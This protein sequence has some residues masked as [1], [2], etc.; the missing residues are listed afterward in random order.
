MRDAGRH[1]LHGPQ[2]SLAMINIVDSYFERLVE[3][4]DVLKATQEIRHTE[5]SD[6]KRRGEPVNKAT[7]CQHAISLYS[8][9][10]TWHAEL[11]GLGL[12]PEEIPSE[13]PN[14]PFPT[15]LWYRSPGLGAMFMG[16]WA[17]LLVI[18][19]ALAYCQDSTCQIDRKEQLV[20][21]I[22]Q[23]V[24]CVGEDE[25]GLYRIAF[26]IHIAFEFADYEMQTW[27]RTMLPRIEVNTLDIL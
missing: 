26:A 8:R 24:E 3:L 25:V 22:L 27:I 7:L 18:Q 5:Y 12:N 1:I 13:N 6:C 20:R 17:S 19:E 16:Y 23:S 10:S 4:L 11:T 21:N 2:V 15:M 9:F 14:S